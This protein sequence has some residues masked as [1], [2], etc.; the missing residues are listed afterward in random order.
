MIQVLHVNVTASIV[1]H[2]LGEII[3][4]QEGCFICFFLQEA[5]IVS[6]NTLYSYNISQ[7]SH[8]LWKSFKTWKITKKSSMHGKIMELKNLNNHGKVMEFCEI[9]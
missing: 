8:K 7:G 1:L 5:Q 4:G 3:K 2:V 6:K 9:I